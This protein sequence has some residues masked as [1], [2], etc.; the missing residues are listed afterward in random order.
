MEIEL[1]HAAVEPKNIL[2]ATDFSPESESALQYALA[3]AVRYRSKIDL[4]HVLE[5]V[6]HD[7]LDTARMNV[8]EEQLRRTAEERMEKEAHEIRSVPHQIHLVNG[9]AAEMIDTVAQDTAADLVVLGTKGAEGISKLL[10]GSTAEEVFRRV[11]CPVLIIGPH[12]QQPSPEANLK[13]I[14]FPTDLVSDE[15]GATASAVSLAQKHDT[16]LTLLHVLANVRSYLKSDFMTF[17]KP[18]VNLMRCLIPPEANL[19]NAPKHLIYY[20]ESVP[21]AVVHVARELPADLI[22]LSVRPEERWA[23]RFPDKAYRIIAH[24]PCP[25]LTLREGERAGSGFDGSGHD[26]ATKKLRKETLQ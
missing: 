1:M 23:T 13:H 5:P 16:N 8:V 20:W 21:D 9:V 3:I 6:A 12:V 4:V 17:E 2:I 7:F 18:Y 15:C 19:R 26:T 22:V 14:L 24:S 25:V 10:N 11:S